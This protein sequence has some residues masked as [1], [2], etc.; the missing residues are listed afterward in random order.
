MSNKNRKNYSNFHIFSLNIFDEQYSHGF[1][2]LQALYDK[3][4]LDVSTGAHWIVDSVIVRES[5]H[6]PFGYVF[7]QSRIVN[8]DNLSIVK[9]DLML[10]GKS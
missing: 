8:H 6:S 10:T 4:Q 7:A 3:Y 2:M 9:K 1:A 5:A